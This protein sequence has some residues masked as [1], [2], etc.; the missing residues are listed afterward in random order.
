MRTA[1][2]V[3]FKVYDVSR[4]EL[5]NGLLVSPNFGKRNAV[6]LYYVSLAYANLRKKLQVRKE[7][8]KKSMKVTEKSLS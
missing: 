7:Y 5:R 8:K 2:K 1:Q 3:Y 4:E 6:G